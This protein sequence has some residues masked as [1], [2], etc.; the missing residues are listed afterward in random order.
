VRI[1]VDVP[2]EVRPVI[3]PGL[4]VTVAVDT[5]PAAGQ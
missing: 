5:K 4:S 2:A 3:L 1:R